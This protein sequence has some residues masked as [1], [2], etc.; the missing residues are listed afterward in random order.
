MNEFQIKLA[1][2]MTIFMFQEYLYD[3]CVAVGK[4]TIYKPILP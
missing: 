3:S 1:L 2:A 4:P